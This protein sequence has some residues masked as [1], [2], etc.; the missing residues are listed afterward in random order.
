[1]F[2]EGRIRKFVKGATIGTLIKDYVERGY[3]WVSVVTDSSLRVIDFWSAKT[4]TEARDKL[5]AMWD[6]ARARRI[7][8]PPYSGFVIRIIKTGW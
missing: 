8:E 2:E 3:E 5:L 7:G 1:M 4:E 6:K